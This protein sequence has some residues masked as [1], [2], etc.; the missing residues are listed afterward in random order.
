[1]SV[2]FSALL[3]LM[4]DPRRAVVAHIRNFFSVQ[5]KYG[6]TGVQIRLIGAIRDPIAIWIYTG[7]A[8]VP[9]SEDFFGAQQ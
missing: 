8:A 3:S 9:I 1:M 7:P 4:L 6:P 2:T 5:I